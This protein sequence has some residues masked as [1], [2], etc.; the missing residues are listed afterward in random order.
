VVDVLA[1]LTARR[2]PV[3][4]RRERVLVAHDLLV[5]SARERDV[6]APVDLAQVEADALPDEVVQVLPVLEHLRGQVRIQPE[7]VVQVID[8]QVAVLL[9]GAAGLVPVEKVLIDGRS[10][11]VVLVEVVDA[12]DDVL[13]Q[14]RRRVMRGVLVRP[15]EVGGG[16]L[17]RE[18]LVT[19]PRGYRRVPGTHVHAE[20]ERS[21]LRAGK[22]LLDARRDGPRRRGLGGLRR[23]R[24]GSGRRLPR[25]E[26]LLRH[27]GKI[28]ALRRF[29]FG[30]VEA[31][32]G[33]LIV[34]Q[35]LLVF[36][37][38]VRLARPRVVAGVEAVGD[39]VVGRRVRTRY[40]AFQ[41]LHVHVRQ[42]SKLVDVRADVGKLDAEAG[43][44][45]AHRALDLDV[46]TTKLDFLAVE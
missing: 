2:G 3:G 39:A 20:I 5:D 15:E 14:H 45:G 19:D 7:P 22:L 13:E 25:L 24:R 28:A 23:L 32:E 44:V 6:L 27:E 18:Q 8:P 26:R 21:R 16:A 11:L 38:H 37:E 29:E 4:E 12:M 10:G 43:E 30:L 33:F 35:R 9:G 34:E 46:G 36:G 42:P 41:H 31:L 40:R 1:E 17:A